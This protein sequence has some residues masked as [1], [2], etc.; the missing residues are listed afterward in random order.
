[1]SSR[2]SWPSSIVAAVRRNVAD[3]PDLFVS[4]SGG[5]DATTIVGALS[6]DLGLSGVQCFSYALGPAA[7]S[8]ERCASET[9]ALAGF[10]YR[11]FRS[12]DGDLVHAIEINAA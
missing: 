2:P 7:D 5:Y 10:G 9:A 3:D 12:Y 8:D 6:S 1:M 4:L 11:R